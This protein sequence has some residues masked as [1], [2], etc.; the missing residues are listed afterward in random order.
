MKR[1]ILLVGLLLLTGLWGYGQSAALEE[2]LNTAGIKNA[3]VSVSVKR[4]SDGKEI[5]A[6]NA[7]TALT[8]ASVAKIL[9]TWFA[10]QEKGGNYRYRTNI[11]YTGVIKDGVLSGDIIVS[12]AGD[13]TLDSRFFPHHSFVK[14]LVAAI[15]LAG[16]KQINGRLRVEGAERG[17]DIPGSWVW[18]DVSNYYGALYL[19]FNYRDNTCVFSFQTGEVGSVAKLISVYPALPGIEIQNEVKAAA[20]N[21]DNAWV[22]GGPY[23]MVL[24]VKGTLPAHCKS[25][26][27]KAALHDPATACVH[28]LETL[29]ISKG[30]GIENNI[31]ADTARTRLIYFD[32]PR[33]EEIVFHTNKASVNLFAEAMGELAGG[34]EWQKGVSALLVKA[35]INTQGITLYDACGLSP[36][37]ALP[38]RVLTD[39]L[40]YIGKR[41][42][43][44]FLNS[45]PLGGVDGGLSGYCHTYP[46]LNGNLQAKTGSMSGVRSLSGYLT[47]NKRERLAFTIL[48]NHYTCAVAQLQ[49]AVGKF[50]SRLME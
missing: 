5:V 43:T 40:V 39:L 28:E 49:R 48:I 16:I 10:L 42:Y 41:E 34:K 2:L 35:G 36:L 15:Q 22:Y 37:D 9:P 33:L 1:G 11:F 25:F 4:V 12:A 23:S 45:L 29:L 50:L 7:E 32:S 6:C 27:I 19:P 18:E 46:Q 38:A 17:T 47:N 24:C 44:A 30:I 20:A 21:R 14:G 8:P 31:L 26:K 3:A 13:P